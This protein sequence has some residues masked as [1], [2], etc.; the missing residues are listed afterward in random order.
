LSKIKS[1]THKSHGL[2]VTSQRLEMMNKLNSTGAQVNIF[3]LKN[4]N[5]QATGTRVELMIPL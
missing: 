5:G 3:D 4:E 2:K 1:A